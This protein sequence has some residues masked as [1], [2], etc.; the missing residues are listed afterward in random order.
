MTPTTWIAE[1]R[2]V[3]VL[4][5]GRRSVGRIAVGLPTV[6]PD[7]ASCLISLDG[8]EPC[9]SIGGVSTLQALLLATRFLGMRLHDFRSCGGRVL[10]PET[11]EELDVR[12][13]FGPLLAAAEAPDATSR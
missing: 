1:E 4:P 10:D 7:N 8:L 9:P 5:D 6:G 12:A 2:V 13:L 3:F 11:D